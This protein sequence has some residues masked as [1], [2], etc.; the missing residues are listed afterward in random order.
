MKLSKKLAQLKNEN[1]L[2]TDALSQRSGIPRGTINKIL[3]GET[4][5]PT[6]GTLAA[7]ADALDCPL[8]YLCD[9]RASVAA[10]P[11]DIPGV[12]KLGDEASWHTGLRN[13]ESILPVTSKRVPLLGAIAAG[14]PIYAEETL[15]TTECDASMHCDFAL[16]VQGDSM[17]GAR[18]Q[19]GDIVFIRR[20]DDV[21]D[22]QI[23]AVIVED[24]ATLKRVYHIKNGLQLLSENPKYPPMVFTLEDYASIRILGR[25]VGFTSRL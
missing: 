6:I 16:R 18:I 2:T 3:N 12:Y 11:E 4:R 23:A 17:I 14:T 5:N 13:A 21:D 20:Q 7:L 19:D 15:D 24:E 1:G 9:E 25:A 8:A 22:G 10:P